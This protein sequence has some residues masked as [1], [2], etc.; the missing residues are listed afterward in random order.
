MIPLTR[1]HKNHCLL[2]QVLS[3]WNW[4]GHQ[5]QE[6]EGKTVEMEDDGVFFLIL[7]DK[8]A[9]NL[10]PSRSL[11]LQQFAKILRD[12]LSQDAPETL[13]AQ[14]DGFWW[15]CYFSHSKRT[16]HWK[17]TFLAVTLTKTLIICCRYGIILPSYLYNGVPWKPSHEIRES[18][19]NQSGFILECQPA[20]DQEK[21]TFPVGGPHI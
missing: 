13:L 16:K 15:S 9:N 12:F 21:G 10:L 6:W 4:A 1:T 3:D 5:G 11:I 18:P 7:R 14:A 8:V 17:H 20:I 2:Y 19:I